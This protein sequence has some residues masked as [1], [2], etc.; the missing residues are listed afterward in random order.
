MVDQLV[1]CGGNDRR[2]QLVV[3]PNA[4]GLVH[5]PE[6]RSLQTT[7]GFLRLHRGDTGAALEVDVG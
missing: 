5:V 7:T 6:D 4:P 2:A 1:L 3:A